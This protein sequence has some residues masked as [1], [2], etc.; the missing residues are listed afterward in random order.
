MAERKEIAIIYNYSKDWIGGVYYLQNLICAL[1]TLNDQD[2]PYIKVYC[3]SSES[4][5]DL[6]LKT[7]YP[8]LIE[9]R[10]V[11][12]SNFTSRVINK[13]LRTINPYTYNPHNG[14]KLDNFESIIYPIHDRNLFNK[15]CKLLAWIPDFQEKYY[16]HFFSPA[17]IKH[18]DTKCKSFIA[19]H[20]PIVFSSHDALNDFNKFYN[21]PR[22]KTFVL[23]FAV[24]LPDFSKE[25]IFN[26][27]DKYNINSKYL[28]CANQFWEHKNHLFLF[29]AFNEFRKK[30][31]D[32]QLVCSGALKDYRNSK[33]SNEIL[34]FIKN[35]NL[36]NHIKILGFI[37]RTEQLCLMNN[38][39]AIIQPS[40]FEG[41]STVVEDA[42]A[43]NKFIFLSNLKVHIEQAPKN[44]CYFDPQNSEDLINKLVSVNPTEYN[45]NYQ[46]NIK[47]FA[48]NFIK[49]IDS[50]N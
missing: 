42:K 11:I 5:K 32:F 1:S 34:S 21:T 7:Q 4:F 43:L 28:F 23:P 2:K 41:W 29:K 6:S 45:H 10:F 44:V 39:Y 37:D 18:R 30:G 50:F 26:I 40:L 8:Y 12:K 46:I 13:I 9:R 19:N 38:S 49:I 33:Y 48:E 35:N 17:E 36:E 14:I 15:K 3:P 47:Q 22:T 20:I 25:D 27:K 31:Y 24:T 16:P